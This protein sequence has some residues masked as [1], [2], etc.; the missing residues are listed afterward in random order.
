MLFVPPVLPRDWHGGQATGQE[1]WEPLMS[2]DTT[3]GSP[4]MLGWDPVPVLQ[5]SN[6]RRRVQTALVLLA[7]VIVLG[8]FAF[9]GWGA[10]ALYT[11]RADLA[12]RI[13]PGATVEGVEVGWM[14]RDQ[15]VAA[16]SQVVTPQLD[17][18]V[19]V[20]WADRTWPTSPRALGATADVEARVDE[21]MAASENPSWDL[22]ARFRFT[23]AEL[24]MAGDVTITQPAEQ[25]RS[26]LSTVAATIDRA[27]RDA[28]IDYSTR[29]VTFVREE[30]GLATD[31][32]AAHRDLMTRFSEGGNEVGLSVVPVAPAVTMEAF[33]DVML[34]DQ[35]AHT[36]A[37]Y[38]DGQLTNTWSVATGT[39]DFPTPTGEFTIGAKRRLPTWVNPSP[40]G[41][42]ADLPP[43]IPPGP[44]NPLG[45]RALNW[46][47]A[48]GNDTAIRFHGT[49]AV[50][51]IGTDASH[52]C[53]RM[54][55][56]DVV[57][58]FDMVDVGARVVSIR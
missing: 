49:N 19:T 9:A 2:V 13:L 38:Q 18:T 44:G 5:G 55:N 10:Y 54:R 25:A 50:G 32:D 46:H 37:L 52:G 27:P 20:R 35:R 33:K 16:V 47:D 26:W 1:A 11:F 12:G 24:D 56:G 51:S 45:L 58:L 28:A 17:R 57:A 30:P 40:K 43:S 34:V 15:A 4:T 31:L 6:R 53:V 3:L 39:G 29:A 7:A 21:V 36:V 42:G 23:G 22:L 8:A 48:A 41:W 14:T